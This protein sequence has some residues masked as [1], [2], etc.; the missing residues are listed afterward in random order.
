MS[1]FFVAT[2]YL[3][4]VP[5]IGLGLAAAAFFVFGGIGLIQLLLEVPFELV[6]QDYL[7]TNNHLHEFREGMLK[8]LRV[9][10]GDSHPHPTRTNSGANEVV[11]K[12]G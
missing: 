8:K 3:I 7:C 6:M 11:T 9:Y 12:E 10:T 5:V 4:I 2:R 1:R